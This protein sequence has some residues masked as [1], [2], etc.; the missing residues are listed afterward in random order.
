MKLIVFSDSHGN[1]WNMK[2]V[3]ELHP[4]AE[5]FIFLGD[6][7]SD[8]DY[9]FANVSV[10]VILVK[11]NCDWNSGSGAVNECVLDMDGKK[12]MC[13]HGHLH[14]VKGGLS[15]AAEYAAARCVDLLLYGH[16]H[17]AFESRERGVV[18]FNPGSIRKGS[19][20]VVNIEKGQ[21]LCSHGFIER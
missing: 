20:G 13:M 21:I 5:A 19:F 14:G 17:I 9:A 10:P 18:L 12:I 6:G 8:T 2:R 3:A 7:L 15:D 1:Y 4:D 11:G 16:T